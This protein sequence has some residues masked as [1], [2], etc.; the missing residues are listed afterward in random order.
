MDVLDFIA[1]VIDSLSWPIGIVIL[2]LLLR[3]HL[4][5]LLSRLTRIRY[6][7]VEVNFRREMRKLGSLA[8]IVGLRSSE[9]PV[10]AGKRQRKSEDAIADAMWLADELP[11][12]AVGVAWV[13]LEH[14]L[15]QAIMRLAISADYPLYQ[16]SLK[17][18][19]LL[20]EHGYIDGKIREVLDRMRRL[21]NAAV[22]AQRDA[23][24]IS[25]DEAREFIG[26]AEAIIAKVRDMA[27]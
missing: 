3:N 11:E 25:G 15:M 17:N 5:K 8:K 18:I 2:T 9:K 21:R 13:A 19:S 27:R 24:G 23:V 6:G 16:S 4:G 12:A 10:Q 14:E 26:L 7:D 22:H 1:S 20:H